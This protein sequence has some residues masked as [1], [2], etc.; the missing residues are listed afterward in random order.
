M[1]TLLKKPIF[2]LLIGISLFIILRIPSLFEPHWYG[3]EG[4]YAAVSEE[5]SHGEILYKDIW[6]DK[7]PLIYWTFLIAGSSNKLFFARLFNLIAGVITI[8]GIYQ[9]TKKLFNE[10]IALVSFFLSIL[11]LG[12]PILEGNIANGENFFL[13]FVVWG[14]LLA[15]DSFKNKKFQFL[16]GVLFS[17]ATLYKIIAILDFGAIVLYLMASKTKIFSKRPK[18]KDIKNL[19][20]IGFGF[21]V[22]LILVISISILNNNFSNFIHATLL[23]M[24]SYVGYSASDTLG[25]V[26]I[27]LSIKIKLL[28]FAFALLFILLN[29]NAKKLAKNILFISLVLICE[30]FATWT[31]DRHYIHYLLQ[32][33]PG[34]ALV[35]AYILYK[36]QKEKLYVSKVNIF[37]IFLLGIY[38]ALINFT[39]GGGLKTNYGAWQFEDK[40]PYYKTYVYY[41]NFVNY[42][43]LHKISKDEYN[44][45]FNDEETRIITL[46]RTLDSIFSDVSKNE[47]YIYTDRAWTYPYLDIPVTT[48]FSVAYHRYIKEN[49]DAILVEDLVSSDPQL[50]VVERGVPTFEGFDLFLVKSYDLVLEDETYSYYSKGS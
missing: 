12:L 38:L 9:L 33:I 27:R 20:P 46:K 44:Y 6:D 32:V 41:E 45:L 2:L 49:G 50:I 10:K 31:S 40:Q 29:F 14:Y 36:I 8:I 17:I 15:I 42:K 16:A 11:L 47:I 26:F 18:F 13:P 39:Q 37:I 5:M 22:P 30:Y 4:I 1:K 35:S 34:F 19:L 25:L 7:P 21:A 24:F 28:L 23:D 3:D 48:Y 43:I